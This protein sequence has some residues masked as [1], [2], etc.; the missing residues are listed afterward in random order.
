ME[1]EKKKRR[2]YSLEFKLEALARCKEVGVT[3]TS[4]ELGVCTAN[5]NRWRNE[6]ARGEANGADKKPS[7]EELEK[8]V[9]RLKKENG[10]LEEINRILKKSTAIFSSTHLGGSK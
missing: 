8:E 6:L 10:W 5:L 1:R 2:I 9:R 4:K 3:Q 7:Y